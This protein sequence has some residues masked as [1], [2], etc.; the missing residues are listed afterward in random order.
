MKP[1]DIET[2]SL[3]P[4]RIWCLVV[5]DAGTYLVFT[6]LHMERTDWTKEPSDPNAKLAGGRTEFLEYAERNPGWAAH[7]GLDFDVPVVNRI[8]RKRAINPLKVVDTLVSSRLFN[9]PIA[10]PTKDKAIV[11]HGL[12]AWGQRLGEPKTDFNDYSCLSLAMID[13]CVQDVKVLVKL[14]AHLM[15]EITSPMWKDSLRVEHD[16]Q[17]ICSGMTERGFPFNRD[18]AQKFLVELKARTEALEAEFQ[19]IWPPQLVE[20]NRLKYSITKKGE[21]NHHVKT[22]R[23][24]YP[25]V[26]RDGDFLVCLDYE[27]FDPASPMKRI[28]KLWEAGWRPFAK[29][30]GHIKFARERQSDPDKAARYARY[31]WE[32]SEENLETLPSDAPDGA[33]KLAEWLCVN[34]RVMRLEEWLGCYNTDTGCIHG[35]FNGIGAWTHRMSHNSPNQANIFSAFHEEPKSVVEEI[36]KKYDGDLRALWGV[37]HWGQAPTPVNAEGEL[38]FSLVPDDDDT[39]WQVGTDA[40]GIQL[41]VLSHYLGDEGYIRTVS[42]GD[43]ADKTDAHNVNRR[44][45]GETICKSRDDA[46]TFVYAFLLGGMPPKLASILGCPLGEGKTAYTNFMENTPGLKHLKTVIIPMLA[47]R[48]WFEGFDGRRVKCNSEHLMLSGLLQCGEAVV[49]KHANRLWRTRLKSD[50]LPFWQAD[51]VHD[52]WQTLVRGKLNAIHVGNVQRQAIVDTGVALGIKCPLAG[53]TNI[54]RNWNEC[55]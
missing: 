18:G 43:K 38:D 55:H 21:E 9:Y 26:R 16:I 48:G 7:N 41:R 19:D 54:G 51:F 8:L 6:N 31:G 20:V 10:T 22:A 39:W 40:D 24:K 44:A 4:E 29:T 23:G 2:E 45:I 28:D 17:I 36:K 3:T 52:E 5:Y 49:M 50:G 12:E 32:C 33:R 30:K 13:Y 53:S 37:S 47:R 27:P 42:E 34:S 46:K 11:G 35:R 15:P 25:L 1:F 14:L